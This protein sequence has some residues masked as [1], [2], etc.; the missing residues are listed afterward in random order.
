MHLANLERDRI[1]V[2]EAEVE[3]LRRLLRSSNE[4]IHLL[5]KELEDAQA[6]L[7]LPRRTREPRRAATREKA[8]AHA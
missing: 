7:K 8:H 4:R 2:L 5:E 6:P 1:N 3:A